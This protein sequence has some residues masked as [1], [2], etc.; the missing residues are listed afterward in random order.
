MPGHRYLSWLAWYLPISR[1]SDSLLMF[2]WTNHV[3]PRQFLPQPHPFYIKTPSFQASGLKPLSPAWYMFQP[4]APP[5]WLHH[6]VD[7]SVSC[8]RY[9]S[10][11]SSIIK[12]PH[13]FTSRW[14]SVR[15]SWV[16][17][18]RKLSGGFP[19]RFFQPQVPLCQWEHQA[20]KIWQTFLCS[21]SHVMCVCVCVC[22]RERERE[23]EG[24][25][26]RERLSYLV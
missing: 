20:Q 25:G 9:V 5:L 26:E 6:V 18:E 1:P 14:S 11:R 7:T 24:E 12:L 2:K 21:R 19:T 16:H 3:K 4:G 17:T 10:A 15:D 22:V 13:A 23:R 8:G